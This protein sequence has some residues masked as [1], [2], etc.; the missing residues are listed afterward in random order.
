MRL[1]PNQH[2]VKEATNVSIIVV[3]PSQ[4]GYYIDCM[5]IMSALD[6]C[7]WGHKLATLHQEENM[8]LATMD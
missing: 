6:M 8:L 7:S 3:W 4:I 1:Q 2:L 5:T